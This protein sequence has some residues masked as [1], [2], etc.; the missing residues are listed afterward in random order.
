MITL[1]RL[2]RQAVA[3]GGDLAEEVISSI[4]TVHAFGIQTKLQPLYDRYIAKAFL[5][6]HK[7]GAWYGMYCTFPEYK[8]GNS[9][10]PL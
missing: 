7:A 9:T 10:D 5:A 1:S 2:S 4:R 6:D 3:E 8:Y